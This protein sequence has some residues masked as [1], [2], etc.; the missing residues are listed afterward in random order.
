MPQFYFEGF[1]FA[2]PVTGSAIFPHW[3]ELEPLRLVIGQLK[4]RLDTL[5]TPAVQNDACSHKMTPGHA[6]SACKASFVAGRAFNAW[7]TFLARHNAQKARTHVFALT[8]NDIWQT[9]LR[10]AEPSLAV[11][12]SVRWLYGDRHVAF[13]VM[14]R[15]RC[16]MH[17]HHHHHHYFHDHHRAKRLHEAYDADNDHLPCIIGYVHRVALSLFMVSR[18]R[19]HK[20]K[21]ADLQAHTT[22]WWCFQSL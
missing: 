12:V 14:T 3:T 5:L 8:A 13:T 10:N 20:C 16:K 18:W 19:Q 9:S 11:C 21:M 17:H 2:S 1:I 4:I 7:D 15:W 22:C 6:K